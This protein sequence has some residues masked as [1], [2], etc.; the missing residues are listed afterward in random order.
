M[1]G[2]FVHSNSILENLGVVFWS[3]QT[4]C[5]IY[6]TSIDIRYEVQKNLNE[7]GMDEKLGNRVGR[8]SF[9]LDYSI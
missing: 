8:T 4:M 9:I 6:I 1:V 5:K 3:F 7:S 2:L